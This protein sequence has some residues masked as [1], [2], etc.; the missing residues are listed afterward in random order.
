[1]NGVDTKWSKNNEVVTLIKASENHL[2]LRVVTP[3]D[4]NYLRVS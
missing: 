3:M 4:R 1:M 2:D